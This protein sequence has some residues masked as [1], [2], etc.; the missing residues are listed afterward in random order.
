MENSKNN[1]SEELLS[2]YINGIVLPL[3]DANNINYSKKY[4]KLLKTI[5]DE[6]IRLTPSSI[7]NNFYD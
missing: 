4:E 6:I 3:L 5:A 7:H 1:G 2:T